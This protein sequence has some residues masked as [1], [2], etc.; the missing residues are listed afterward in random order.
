[1]TGTPGVKKTTHVVKLAKQRFRLEEKYPGVEAITRVLD[2]H[3]N[4]L[5]DEAKELVHAMTNP[6]RF[7]QTAEQDRR[8]IE[9]NG[10][11]AP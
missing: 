7:Y 4:G 5:P 8:V 3:S 6:Y 1:M 2:E 10:H 9:V 11:L